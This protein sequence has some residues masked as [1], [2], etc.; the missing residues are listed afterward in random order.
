[1]AGVTET[2]LH[3]FYRTIPPSKFYYTPPDFLSH[4]IMASFSLV[5]T[6]IYT[7]RYTH[8][9]ADSLTYIA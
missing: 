8:M 3:H 6:D 9:Y 7:Q 4:K 2:K 5:V 1:M